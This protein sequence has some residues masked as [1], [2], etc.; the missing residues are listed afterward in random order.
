M[1][2]LICL[3]LMLILV[4]PSFAS[5]AARATKDVH[6][7][8][9]TYSD[10]YI[11]TV[12]TALDKKLDGAGLSYQDSCRMNVWCYTG[13]TWEVL[14]AE[15]DPA[16]LALLR[17]IDVLVDGPFILAQ[18]SLEL[19]YCG[20]RNQRLIDVKK[21]LVAGEVILWQPPTW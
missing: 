20:S 12:R 11:S 8:Y 4:L 2:K 7:F 17:Q 5:C 16:R 18:R 15:D 21:S 1:K 13:Y 14:M 6:V 10:T 3:I 19:K 9:Y